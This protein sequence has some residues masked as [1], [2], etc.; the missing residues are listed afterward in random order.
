MLGI[1]IYKNSY[2]ISI[3]EKESLPVFISSTMT[4]FS[5]S[6]ISYLFPPLIFAQL[7]ASAY[8]P[9]SYSGASGVNGTDAGVLAPLGTSVPST[10]SLGT[11]PANCADDVAWKSPTGFQQADCQDAMIEFYDG[12]VKGQENSRYEFLGRDV[13]PL[14][15]IHIT[16][17]PLKITSGKIP[18]TASTSP[19]EQHN[20]GTNYPT[21]S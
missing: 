18:L 7:A 5:F 3:R 9:T 21:I 6:R 19:S 2:D 15:A 11:N 8:I 1:L 17:L 4:V 13:K 20:L 12:W 10:T 16:R 14:R